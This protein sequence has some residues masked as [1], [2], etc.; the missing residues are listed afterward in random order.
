MR[1]A[2]FAGLL[3]M[4]WGEKMHVLMLTWEYPP[5]AVGGLARHVAGLSEAM[6]EDGTRVTVVSAGTADSPSASANGHRV[7]RAPGGHPPALDF[8]GSVHHLNF[9]LLSRVMREV[10]KGRAFDLVHAHDWLAAFAARAVK[11]ALRI[12]MIA[13][14]HST[15]WGRHH[16]LHSPLQRYISDIEWWLCYEAWRVIVCSEAM[17]GEVRSVFQVPADK[18]RVI[19]NGTRLPSR[20][21]GDGEELRRFRRQ[22]CA[23]EEMLLFYVGRLVREKGVQTLIEAVCRL[24]ASGA[25]VK[26][27]VAGTGPMREELERLAQALGVSPHVYFTGYV[28]DAVRDGLLQAADAAVFPS[29]YEPFGIVAL[30]SMAAGLPTIVSDVGGLREIVEHGITGWRT[31]PGDAYGLAETIRHVLSD[32]RRRRETARRAQE[33]VAVRYSWRQVARRTVD[34]YQGVLVE[35]ESV[36]WSP[37]RRTAAAADGAPPAAAPRQELAGRYGADAVSGVRSER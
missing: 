9:E 30:E 31:P 26:L 29:L 23:D 4:R 11:H 25:A 22:Y 34:V 8:A 24:R 1:S 12:P 18:V 20:P 3:A 15:E 14:I 37:R 17:R 27:V 7:L 10:D 33:E 5:N 2:G 28:Q 16:G 6:A 35:S 32:P 19:P 36:R 13:T 21:L